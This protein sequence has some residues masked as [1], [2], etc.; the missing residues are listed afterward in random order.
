MSY[1]LT[2][3]E[4]WDYSCQFHNARTPIPIYLSFCCPASYGPSQ[5]Y[6]TFILIRKMNS[7]F[8]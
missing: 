2:S 8:N 4:C 6:I 3:L 5:K 7:S 1:G